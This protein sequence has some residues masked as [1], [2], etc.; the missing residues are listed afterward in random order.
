MPTSATIT[1]ALI[2]QGSSW[3]AMA[4]IVGLDAAAILQA[5][6]TSIAYTI[7]K[8]D[9][10]AAEDSS[11]SLTVGTVIFD[12]LQTQ[13]WSADTT[14]YNFRWDVPAALLDDAETDY[15]VHAALTMADGSIVPLQFAPRTR[16]TATG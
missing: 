6:V 8:R 16:R 9:T 11:G 3:R 15:H 5:D 1:Q 14:G 2:F 12:A 10:P 4:R 13:S 7:W